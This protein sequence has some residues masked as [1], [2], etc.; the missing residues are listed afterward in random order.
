MGR[1]TFHLDT[2][3]GIGSPELLDQLTEL[4]YDRGPLESLAMGLDDKTGS[5]SFN[6]EIEAAGVET[7]FAN[8]FRVLTA[9]IAYASGKTVEASAELTLELPLDRIEIAAA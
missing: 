2:S 3:A 9:A 8:A 4:L 6:F 1:Y 5:L 7:A